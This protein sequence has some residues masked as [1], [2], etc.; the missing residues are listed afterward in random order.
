MSPT[1]SPGATE[2][3]LLERTEAAKPD[4]LFVEGQGSLTHPSYSGVTLGLLHGAAPNA[5]VLCHQPSRRRL[6]R[7]ELPIPPLD[8]LIRLYETAAGWLEPAP[9]AAVALNT[10][11]LSDEEAQAAVEEAQRQT[12]LPA[13]DPIRFGAAPLLDALE[14]VL[15]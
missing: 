13:S 6:A 7:F 4:W 11:D 14:S 10:F 5:M 2:Q 8:A 12:G 9:V 15:T 3:I 1:L